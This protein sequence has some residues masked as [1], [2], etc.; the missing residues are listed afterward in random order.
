MNIIRNVFRFLFQ[1]IEIEVSFP[2]T[3]WVLFLLAVFI[4]MI[5]YVEEIVYLYQ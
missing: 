4:T 1:P 3:V 2:L 5:S